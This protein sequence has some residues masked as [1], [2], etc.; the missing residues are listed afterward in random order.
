MANLAIN[1]IFTTR[2]GVYGSEG[3]LATW[4]ASEVVPVCIAN[5]RTTRI[6]PYQVDASGQ[7]CKRPPQAFPLIECTRIAAESGSTLGHVYQMLD[8]FRVALPVND[9]QGHGAKA[10]FR[11]E[12][13][14]MAYLMVRFWRFAQTLPRNL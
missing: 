9:L 11:Q 2:R 7:N 14:W 4:Q 10:G 13:V 8:P 1:D 6:L 3:A 12:R 5:N